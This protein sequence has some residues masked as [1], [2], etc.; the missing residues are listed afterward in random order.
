[1]ASICWHMHLEFCLYYGHL[2]CA[3]EAQSCGINLKQWRNSEIQRNH[4]KTTLP[5]LSSPLPPPLFI[6]R[7]ERYCFP[8][9]PPPH[10]TLS[11]SHTRARVHIRDWAE[12]LSD[13]AGVRTAGKS[14]GGWCTLHSLYPWQHRHQTK[15]PPTVAVLPKQRHL[16]ALVCVNKERG[17]IQ[18]W[19]VVLAT[20]CIKSL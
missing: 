12:P 2:S 16:C 19:S 3:T 17:Q 11:L 13:P 20:S 18:Q 8:S 14:G 1:M 6:H 4:K 7:K 10:Q 9:N 5:L 15:P